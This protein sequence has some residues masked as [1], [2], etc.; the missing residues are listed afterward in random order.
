MYAQKQELP[1]NIDPDGL[2]ISFS[3]FKKRRWHSTLI[4]SKYQEFELNSVY[5]FY[6]TPAYR[7]ANMSDLDDL[8]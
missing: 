3:V 1:K 8:V 5:S 4:M 6:D 2:L 7:I